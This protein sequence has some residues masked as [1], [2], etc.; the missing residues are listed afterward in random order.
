MKTIV[1]MINWNMLLLQICRY[2]Y[3]FINNLNNRN[4]KEII[5]IFNLLVLFSRGGN[6]VYAQVPQKLSEEYRTLDRDLYND[7]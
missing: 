1:I 6:G 4:M 5:F 2:Y 7:E 3:K